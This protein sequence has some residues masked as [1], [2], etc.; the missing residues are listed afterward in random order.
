MWLG[1][2]DDDVVWELGGVSRG[3]GEPMAMRAVDG[4]DELAGWK[5]E[6]EPEEGE[7]T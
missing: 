5:G 2:E 1:G 3:I 6:R 7:D 4:G